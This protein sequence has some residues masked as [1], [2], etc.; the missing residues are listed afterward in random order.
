M[1]P[2]RIQTTGTRTFEILTATARMHYIMLGRLFAN[3]NNDTQASYFLRRH[4]QAMGGS[5]DAVACA[6]RVM[7]R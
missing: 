6:E 2:N 7:S 1:M 4:T 5:G 3:P